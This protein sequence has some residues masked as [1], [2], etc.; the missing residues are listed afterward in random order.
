MARLYKGNPFVGRGEEQA[1]AFLEAQ[2]PGAWSII[3]NKELVDPRG[4][5]REVDFIIVAQHTI[6]VVD[7]KSWSGA[8]HGNENGWVLRTGESYLDPLGKTEYLARRLAGMLRRNVPG[9]AGVVRDQD[10]FVLA[11]ILL[12][13]DDAKVFVHDPRVREQVLLLKQCA[14]ALFRVDQ[15]QA[16]LASI[17]PAAKRIVDALT[18]LPDRPKIPR[19]VGD[20]EIL[21]S[22][23]SIG[24]TRL[25][26]GKHADGSHRFLKMIRLPDTALQDQFQRMETALLREYDALRRLAN[27]R[28][29]P[30]VEPFFSWEEG[31]YR[32]IPLN[33]IDGES[34]RAHR[35]E[36]PPAAEEILPVVKS[37][38]TALAAVHEAGIVHR[39]LTPDRIYIENQNQSVALS[40]F[41]I[42]RIEGQQTIAAEA[43]ELDP[44]NIYRAPECRVG[45]EFA[46]AASDVFS[47]AA[48]LLYWITGYEPKDPASPFPKL[49]KSRSELQSTPASFLED[50]LAACLVEDDQ[51]RPSAAQIVEQ[52]AAEQQRREEEARR[53]ARSQT[54][55]KGDIVEDRYEIRRVLGQGGTAITYLAYDQTAD[56]LFVLK[57]ILNAEL[58]SELSR[59]EFKVLQSLHHPNLPRVY[60]VY[61]ER[62]PFH[63]KLEYVCGSALREVREQHANVPSC[64]RVA[65]GVLTALDYLAGQGLVHRD[66]S[67]G[68]ILIPDEESQPVKL[69]DFGLATGQTGAT[70]PVGTPPYRAPEVEQGGTW[71]SLCDLYSLAVVLFEMAVG[72]LPYHVDGDRRRKDDLVAPTAEEERRC[73][74]PLLRVLLKAASP[75]HTQRYATASGFLSA[76]EQAVLGRD[77]PVIEEECEEVNPFVE[78]LRRAYR[79]SSIGNTNNRG[80]ESQFSRDT[81]VETK[82]DTE[83]LPQI[84]EGRYRLVIL[85]GNP[86]DGKTAFLQQLWTRL[87]QKGATAETE[88]EAG[89]KM[90]CGDATFAALYDAS[91]SHQGRSADD[92]FHEILEPLRGRKEPADQYSAGIAV[93]DGRLR[94]F[95]ERNGSTY[96]PWL[97]DRLRPQMGDRP[98]SESGVLLVD[99]KRRCL[100]GSSPDAPSLFSGIL[101]RFLDPERWRSCKHCAAGRECPIWANVQ[102]LSNPKLRSA[103]CHRLHRLIL[104]VHLRRERRAT[105]RDLRSALAYLITH[106]C[107]CRTIHEERSKG[108]WPLANISRYYFNAAF[109]GSGG[110]DLLLDEWQQLDPSLVPVPRLDRYLHFHRNQDQLDQIEALFLRTEDRPSPAITT[111]DPRERI[112]ALKRRYIFEAAE[113]RNVG[114]RELPGPAKLIPY[115]HLDDFMETITGRVPPEGIRDRLLLGISRA[116]G[117]P[118]ACDGSGLA[119]RLTDASN[120]ELV[121]IKRY[122]SHEFQ[123]CIP[124][125]PTQEVEILTDYLVLEHTSG[126]PRLVVGLDLFEYLCRAYDGAIPGAEEQRA[127]VED[128]GV[129]KNQLLTRPTQEV[130]ILEA[131]HR[132]HEVRVEEGRIVRQEANV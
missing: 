14:E 97:W 110:P 33:P 66:V 107:G 10:H 39:S 128:L 37:A 100:V 75:D 77:E 44:D 86:G 101:D 93:N 90:R 43:P 119:L 46:V 117:V 114:R 106:D 6:F 24:P 32:V 99:M 28:V 131:G 81:Y 96:Y 64:L 25:L 113:D 12:S 103:I 18:G 26:S 61:P 54:F 57:R 85:S 58:Y 51:K 8:I 40:D 112:A 9:L 36:G 7:E 123:I 89:W 22:L 132:S 69:I 31:T 52:L 73:G 3:C 98:C 47:L 84:L 63:L 92:L 83:L 71:T 70:A 13:A 121:V 48:S 79:N 2:L 76:I 55:E 111:S 80:L 4:S 115:R 120:D 105:V 125:I 45:L 16:N 74:R 124:A 127:L 49:L 102:S 104:A 5:T 68:N 72:R 91:E 59:R 20:Y 65:R 35:T 30:A 38:F 62:S 88:N 118:F 23:D 41:V 11:R 42:A 108:Q 56:D 60:D 126:S 21:E 50:I 1:A 34:L 109:D 29:A 94:D 95:F 53:Q 87:K 130:L 67:S 19:R 116:D 17:A 122:P 78:E 15:Q 82:L 129:F 27:R